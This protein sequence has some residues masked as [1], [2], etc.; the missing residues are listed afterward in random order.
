MTADILPINSGL[1]PPQ[2]DANGQF[3]PGSGGR[4][5]GAKN[6]IST[7]AI[8]AIKDMKDEAIEQLRTKL[9]RGD[10]DALSFVLERIV[11]KGR[12][13]EMDS[14][15]PDEIAGMIASGSLTTTEAKDLTAAL[16]KLAEITELATIKDRLAELEQAL[17]ERSR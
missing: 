3:M 10:W 13:V 8:A 7:E 16:A 9:Q 14:T 11:G 17:A 6:R 15:S 12:V 2:R 5:R 4:P 1:Q